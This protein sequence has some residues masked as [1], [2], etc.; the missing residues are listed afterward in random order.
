[1]QG[2]KSLRTSHTCPLTNAPCRDTTLIGPRK[3]L[4]GGCPSLCCRRLLDLCIALGLGPA[5]PVSRASYS[6]VDGADL[7]TAHLIPTTP[8]LEVGYDDS[9]I[10]LVYQHK[11]PT[12]VASFCSD[13]VALAGIL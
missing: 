10:R 5:S 2:L 9:S 1:M 13:E 8:T 7:S 11:A 12:N 6:G 3:T 4:V